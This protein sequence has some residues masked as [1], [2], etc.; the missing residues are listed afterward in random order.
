V[1]R[2]SGEVGWCGCPGLPPVAH[3]M[4]HHWEEPCLSGTRGSGAVFFGGCNLRCV[5]CQ[6]HDIS[7]RPVGEP[8]SPDAL[9]DVF[10]RLQE[11]GAHNVNLVS[12]TP[13]SGYIARALTAA[14]DRGLEIPVVY[15]CNG[16]ETVEALR[17]LDGLV[18]VYLPDLKYF[19]ETLARRFSSAPRYFETASAAL[20]EMDRQVGE[21][22]FD[23]AGLMKKG[24]LVRHLVLPGHTA[25]SA[26]LLEWLAANLPR[27][28]LSLLA[29][30]TPVHRAREFGELARRLS[31]LEYEPLV[32]LCERLGL[33]RGY[34]QE[35]EA[36]D[37]AYI[38]DFPSRSRPA[39]DTPGSGSEADG[40]EAGGPG[41]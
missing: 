12:P 13:Y 26:R 1:D 41:P 24:M 29:Q 10:L 25:D 19:D 40:S 37:E 21:A 3:V 18:D 9:A 20:L 5:F 38:P 6:N 35:I 33:E 36:A 28:H 30:Y 22:V 17:R 15:N 4:L 8:H 31:P 27:A 34:R 16:Y 32:D 39:T 14:R 23:Q 11:S 7:V 2:T